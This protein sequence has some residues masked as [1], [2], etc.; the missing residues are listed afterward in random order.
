M[1]RLLAHANVAPI[2]AV[3]AGASHLCVVSA[4]RGSQWLAYLRPQGRAGGG[5]ELA[6]LQA[7]ARDV[8]PA[9]A[10][11]HAVRGGR[12]GRGP[13]GAPRAGRRAGGAAAVPPDQNAPAPATPWHGFEATSRANSRPNPPT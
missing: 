4:D 12:R 13:A 7:I 11:M 9:L 8:G 1:G 6:V 5:E 3:Y 2:L 10:H